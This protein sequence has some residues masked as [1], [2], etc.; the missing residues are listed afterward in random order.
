VCAEFIRER[1]QR[2]VGRNDVQVA[3]CFSRNLGVADPEKSAKQPVVFGYF[4]RLIRE[5]GIDW[6]LR[7]S[8]DSR[9]ADIEWCVWG[10]ESTYRAADFEG[11]ANV[12]YLGAFADE[13]GLRK[14]LET[15]DC[16]CLFSSHPEGLPVALMEVMG[17]GRPWIATAQGGIPELA[18]DSCVLVS[19]QDYEA[20]VVACRDMRDRLRSGAIDRRRVREFYARKFG[21]PVLYR[22]WCE[23]LG[24][25]EALVQ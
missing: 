3:Y 19:L 9:L 10:A 6:I 4:G 14:A 16:Y 22:R 2:A 7:L 25:A 1:M 21:E 12:R 18:V 15:I 11:S 20:V 5:K 24:R 13:A 23:V 17:A 8:R